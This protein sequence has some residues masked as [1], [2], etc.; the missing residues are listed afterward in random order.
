MENKYDF[1]VIMRQLYCEDSREND[2]VVIPRRKAVLRADTN[3]VIA[4]TSDRYELIEH[5]KVIDIFDG[6][7]TLHREKVDVC[8]GGAIMFAD[9]KLNSGRN[10]TKQVAVGDV[11]DFKIRVFNSYNMIMG[12]GFEVY[13][14]RLVCTNGLM[15]PKSVSRLSYKH[16]IGNEANRLRD[17]VENT[18]A[19]SLGITDQWTD[20]T[21]KKP[22]EEGI[23]DYFNRIN[24]FI[25]KKDSERLLNESKGAN[26][27]WE[28]FNIMTRY[29]THELKT[30]KADMK[31]LRQ[32][33]KEQVLLGNFYNLFGGTNV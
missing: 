5:K 8:Q 6:I 2:S 16:L 14:I 1:P 18:Y 33:D 7:S 31:L 23:G 24:H 28:M 10:T 26:S 27:T 17:I 22:T 32:R 12:I 19:S 29:I 4:V 30:R 15:I 9:Y 20:W 3:E 21:K 25:G 13:A 11:V